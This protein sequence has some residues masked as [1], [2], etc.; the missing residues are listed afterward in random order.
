MEKLTQIVVLVVLI[1]VGGLF[2]VDKA[3][4]MTNSGT[5]KEVESLT[6]VVKELDQKMDKLLKRHGIGD[7]DPRGSIGAPPS[8]K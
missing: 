7:A 6:K 8:V 4:E 3:S 5:A 1:V 2:V